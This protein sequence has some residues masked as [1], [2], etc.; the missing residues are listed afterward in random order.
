MPEGI[1]L[2][3]FFYTSLTGQSFTGGP[4]TTSFQTR[5]IR[6]VGV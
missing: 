4:I 6:V 2:I 3:P 1:Y 5:L